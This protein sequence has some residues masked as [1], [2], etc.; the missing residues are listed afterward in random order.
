MN[1]AI[2]LKTA[3]TPKQESKIRRRP[4]LSAKLPQNIPPQDIPSKVIETEN[5]KKKTK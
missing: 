3:L 5:K 1:A 2:T 4:A